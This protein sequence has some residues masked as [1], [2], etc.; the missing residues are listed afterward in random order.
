MVLNV[1]KWYKPSDSTKYLDFLKD[2]WL[3][4][5]NAIKTDATLPTTCNVFWDE[6]RLRTELV[7]MMTECPD[8]VWWMYLEKELEEDIKLI[9]N[10]I[11]EFGKNLSIYLSHWL[12]K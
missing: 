5:A 11:H 9:E 2:F 1:E 6:S 8:C 7:W 10:V 4:V 12:K 3:A